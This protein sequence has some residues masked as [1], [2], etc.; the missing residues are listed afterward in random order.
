MALPPGEVHF[1][2]GDRGDV[3]LIE[4]EASG[5]IHVM[6]LGKE[7]VAWLALLHQRPDAIFDTA[8]GDGAAD[9]Q[10][11]E[12]LKEQVTLQAEDISWL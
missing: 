6:G 7:D 4:W 5:T 3:W 9:F 1:A 10:P 2:G 8:F 12:V 11:V